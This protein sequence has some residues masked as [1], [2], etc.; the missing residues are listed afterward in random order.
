MCFK[1]TDKLCNVVKLDVKEMVFTPENEVASIR[2]SSFF[3]STCARQNLRV[4]YETKQ[5]KT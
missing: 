1:D 4:T 2:N 5:M 3:D